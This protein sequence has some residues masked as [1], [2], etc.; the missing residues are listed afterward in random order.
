LA[1]EVICADSSFGSGEFVSDPSVIEQPPS[2]IAADV[3]AASA[4]A[5]RGMWRK[6]PEK[7][8]G[9]VIERDTHALTRQVVARSAAKCIGQIASTFTG[10]GHINNNAGQ[11]ARVEVFMSES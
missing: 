8:T 6:F 5:A 4:I 7:G 9:T 10:Q 3:I 2:A 1:E 11:A